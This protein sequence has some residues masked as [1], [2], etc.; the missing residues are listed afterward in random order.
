MM[1]GVAIN[2]LVLRAEHPEALAEFYTLL[3]LKFKLEQ[4]GK[5]PVH[6][7]CEMPGAVFE[8]YPCVGERQSTLGVR[9]GFKVHSIERV[10]STL[11]EKAEILLNTSSA[12]GQ[13]KCVLKDPE[14]HKVELVEA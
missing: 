2:L 11:G 10:L 8:I 13:R 5:G 14:G 3:G 7:A 12:D 6:H 9:V 4:H 1:D